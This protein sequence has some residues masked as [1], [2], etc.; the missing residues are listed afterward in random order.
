MTVS[1]RPSANLVHA[2]AVGGLTL[3][4]ETPL[5]LSH[6]TGEPLGVAL[7]IAVS[8]GVVSFTV[9]YRLKLAT[10]QVLWAPL[11]GAVVGLIALSI[12]WGGFILFNEL[13]GPPQ[14]PDPNDPWNLTPWEGFWFLGGIMAIKVVPTAALIWA[15][16]RLIGPPLARDV[17]GA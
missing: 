12:G 17:F 15:G 2:V 10:S 14:H 9:W 5:V 6:F 16:Y 1:Y 3:I 11:A 8:F 4:V 13:F 7:W